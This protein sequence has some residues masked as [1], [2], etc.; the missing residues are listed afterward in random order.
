MK[1]YL[2]F[3]ADFKLIQFHNGALKLGNKYETITIGCSVIDVRSYIFNFWKS[4]VKFTTKKPWKMM[5][6]FADPASENWDPATRRLFSGAFPVT[7]NQGVTVCMCVFPRFGISSRFAPDSC[8]Q[9]LDGQPSDSRQGVF[10]SA[11][12]IWKRYSFLLFSWLQ[13]IQYLSCIYIYIYI[14]IYI[15]I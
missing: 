10:R 11:A 4:D 14:C 6:G 15:Y 3:P 8:W 7:R 2:V 9:P 1:P 12:N 5:I 13:R